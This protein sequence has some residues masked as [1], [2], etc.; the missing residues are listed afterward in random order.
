MRSV[1]DVC[2]AV[3]FGAVEAV[4]HYDTAGGLSACERRIAADGRRRSRTRRVV[5]LGAGVDAKRR[6]ARKAPT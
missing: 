6:R 3:L 1:C 4:I 2:G 5:S